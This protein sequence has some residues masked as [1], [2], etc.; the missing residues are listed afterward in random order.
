MRVS[1]GLP[2]EPHDI[3]LT[4][5]AFPNALLQHALPDL[6]KLSIDVAH[7]QQKRD[8]LVGTLRNMG[9]AVHLPEGT[10]YLFPQSPW[11]DDWAFAELLA[12]HNILSLPGSVTE[13]PGYFR[14]SL[15]AS[16]EMIDRALPGFE[17]ALRQARERN[18]EP[19]SVAVATGR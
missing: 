10:F 3:L 17:A 11:E 18:R 1:H 14:L 8:R 7:L 9:Y 5:Y 19:A 6:N 2:F 16:D 12:E 13:I 4:G 15:P